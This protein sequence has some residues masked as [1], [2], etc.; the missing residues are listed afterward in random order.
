MNNI[1]CS[2]YDL[3]LSCSFAYTAVKN[4]LDIDEYMKNTCESNGF[5]K[6][7]IFKIIYAKTGLIISFANAET[8]MNLSG[9][10]I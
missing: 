8:Y 5:G 9:F 3:Y 7:T 10:S 6:F 2:T 4:E 1:D